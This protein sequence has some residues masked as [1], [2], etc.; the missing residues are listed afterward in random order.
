MTLLGVEDIDSSEAL[1]F[2]CL[3]EGGEVTLYEILNAPSKN[4]QE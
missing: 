2:L 3:A 4:I 1:E